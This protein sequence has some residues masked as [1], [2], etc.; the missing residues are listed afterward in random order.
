MRPIDWM[1][2][3]LAARC[4]WCCLLLAAA[5]LAAGPARTDSAPSGFRVARDM[6]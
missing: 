2:S 4:A 1:A 6:P 5:P 3:R